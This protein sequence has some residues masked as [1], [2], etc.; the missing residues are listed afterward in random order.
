MVSF[1]GTTIIKTT[2]SLLKGCRMP[3]R[4]LS[5]VS[6]VMSSAVKGQCKR[7]LRK[8]PVMK[9][10]VD[11]G[12]ARVWQEPWLCNSCWIHPLLLRCQLPVN[13]TQRGELKFY[14]LIQ[15]GFCWFWHHTE[16]ALAPPLFVFEDVHWSLQSLGQGSERELLK[17]VNSCNSSAVRKENKWRS[18]LIPFW[19][20][21]CLLPFYH[22]PIRLVLISG[23][24]NM[25]CCEVLIGEGHK[26]L[27]SGTFSNWKS[28]HHRNQVEVRTS[29]KQWH[30]MFNTVKRNPI[31]SLAIY[32]WRLYNTATVSDTY[33]QLIHVSRT[34]LVNNNS[35]VNWY[36]KKPYNHI[37]LHGK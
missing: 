22:N 2:N 16:E 5:G 15:E 18:L 1:H 9:V 10:L 21:W 31:E 36:L 11:K 26:S 25:N 7:A 14:Y 8:M 30:F 19:L 37:H 23:W 35:F 27:S 13:K 28:T 3:C 34:I 17:S 6:F 32:P 4:H 24:K 20:F 33:P 12:P 29:P